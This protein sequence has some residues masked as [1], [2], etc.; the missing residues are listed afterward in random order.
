MEAATNTINAE[1]QTFSFPVVA[2]VGQ[3]DNDLGQT[4]AQLN[5]AAANGETTILQDWGKMSLIGP[6]TLIEGYN[7]LGLSPG[8]ANTIVNAVTKRVWL[9]DSGT[10]DVR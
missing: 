9:I 6:R 8:E 2:E 1:S 4:F 10:V 3:I 7:G 5:S